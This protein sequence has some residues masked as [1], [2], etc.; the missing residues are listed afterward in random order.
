LLPGDINAGLPPRAG[1]DGV[2]IVYLV[3][4]FPTAERDRA[5]NTDPG[6]FRGIHRFPLERYVERFV[7]SAEGIQKAA[8]G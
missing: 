3:S 4:A 8:N 5:D 7:P 1:V 6:N 2:C